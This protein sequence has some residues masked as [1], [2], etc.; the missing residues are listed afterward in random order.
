MLS[1]MFKSVVENLKSPQELEGKRKKSQNI[2]LF[3]SLGY[4][5]EN[6]KS[7]YELL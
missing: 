1:K 7:A 2:C 6:A 5:S 4:Y 3:S